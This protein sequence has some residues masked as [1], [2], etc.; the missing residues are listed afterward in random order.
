MAN[1]PRLTS[2]KRKKIKNPAG[3]QAFFFE[4]SQLFLSFFSA[5]WRAQA[6]FGVLGQLVDSKSHLRR[7]SLGSGD[8]KG[9]RPRLLP[10][11]EDCWDLARLFKGN[12]LDSNSL[13]ALRSILL[14]RDA[15]GCPASM[16]Y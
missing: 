10:L 1:P 4:K 2:F 5:E 7:L 14:I 15:L 12:C 16:D 11:G 9:L 8:G 6:N 3:A 13:T